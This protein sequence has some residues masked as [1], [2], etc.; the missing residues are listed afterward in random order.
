[1]TGATNLFAACVARAYPSQ[2]T[3]LDRAVIDATRLAIR[4]E[5]DE[6]EARGLPLVVRDGCMSLAAARKQANDI[7][8]DTARRA[9]LDELDV[10][11]RRETG[12]RL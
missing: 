5:L 7:R 8:T 9:C 4:A 2:P 6:T 3:A 11:E 12:V 1:M 10:L